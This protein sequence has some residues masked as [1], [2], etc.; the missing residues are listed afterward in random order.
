MMRS[1][2]DTR[3]VLMMLVACVFAP[4]F[5]ILV[6]FGRHKV[7]LAAR[8]EEKLKAV[9]EEIKASG[10]EAAVA[11]GDASKVC[12]VFC[13]FLRILVLTST[14]MIQL[15]YLCVLLTIWRSIDAIHIR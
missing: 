1:R 4:Y 8:N 6:S 2:V 10:G 11:A 3:S 14:T 15:N 9:A 5:F 7:V 13:L 12:S